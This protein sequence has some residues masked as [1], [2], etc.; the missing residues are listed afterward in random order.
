MHG[1][2]NEPTSIPCRDHRTEGGVPRSQIDKYTFPYTE[3][4]S[5]PIKVYSKMEEI[6]HVRARRRVP[7]SQNDKYTFPLY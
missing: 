1:G 6:G 2:D 5:I 3:P 7:R 4:T